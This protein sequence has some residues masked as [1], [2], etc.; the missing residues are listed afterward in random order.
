MKGSDSPNIIEFG[1]TF[2]R[3]RLYVDDRR[4]YR[5][6][7]A[8]GE[9]PAWLGNAAFYLLYEL[10]DQ[11]GKSVSKKSLIDNAWERKGKGDDR[12]D[13][14]RVEINKLRT[15]LGENAHNSCIRTTSEG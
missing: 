15:S 12:E 2:A 11:K 13:N 3:F 9:V 5:L 6:D 8:I 7:Q 4:L 14:L 10:L 1:G